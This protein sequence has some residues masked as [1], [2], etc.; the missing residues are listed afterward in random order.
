MYVVSGRFKRLTS[1]SPSSDWFLCGG[2]L[3]SKDV[4]Y[5][6]HQVGGKPS[7]LSVTIDCL[8]IV[9][10]MGVSVV[11]DFGTDGRLS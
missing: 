7:I 9:G 5:L 1:V 8:G 4:F 2:G 10:F 11:R 3:G 6:D